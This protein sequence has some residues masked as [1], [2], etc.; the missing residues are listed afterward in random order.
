VQAE[1]EELHKAC[2]QL[3]WLT[4]SRGAFGITLPS[5]QLLQN[6]HC[7][8]TLPAMPGLSARRH[9]AFKPAPQGNARPGYRPLAT[10]D[11]STCRSLGYVI[12]SQ[13]IKPTTQ[14]LVAETLDTT[15][16]PTCNPVTVLLLPVALQSG[17]RVCSP[18]H[19][20]QLQKD[21]FCKA[22]VEIDRNDMNIRAGLQ[23]GLTW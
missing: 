9:A 3:F 20:A 19:L 23:R 12:G 1:A 2:R 5:L 22:L 10:L 17:D 4:P 18:C 15:L 21:S 14:P 13:P 11:S 6:I 16:M 7:V 8:H